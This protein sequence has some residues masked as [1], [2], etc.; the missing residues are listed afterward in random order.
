MNNLKLATVTAI[1]LALATSATAGG[2]AEP[3]EMAPAEVLDDTVAAASSN[4]ALIVPLILLA[5][6]AAAS[7]ANG[8][9]GP[10]PCPTVAV[11]CP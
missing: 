11:V 1:G 6:I 5:L 2:L 4:A 8:G 10:P 7:S 3:I 9:D